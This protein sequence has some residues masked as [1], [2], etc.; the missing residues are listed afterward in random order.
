M[1]YRARFWSVVRCYSTGDGLVWF[2]ENNPG[3]RFE[4]RLVGELARLAPDHVIVPI[5]VDPERGWL[6]TDDCGTTLTH[7]D[8]ADQGSRLIVVRALARL[9]SALLGKVKPG[10]ITL[11]PEAAGDRLRAVAREWVA[12]PAGHPLRIDPELAARARVA[13]DVLD[14]RTAALSGTVP[15]DLEFND[16]YPA[17]IFADRSTGVLRPRFFDFGNTL[18]AHPFVTLHGFLDSV[19]DWTRRSLSH[20]DREA[21]YAAYLAV[22]SD[23]LAADPGVLRQDLDVVEP[24]VD[25]HRLVSWQRLIPHADPLE[26]R[27]RAEIP[28]RYLELAVR[29]LRG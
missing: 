8:V 10:M 15:L 7:A 6:L 29:G 16:V 22:W 25:V 19:V 11:A 18:W 13:A 9:Q 27:T 17:N 21:L 14:R 23:H 20:E 5:A 4:A 3:H 1:T 28:R 12:L 24:L 2:K 26:L